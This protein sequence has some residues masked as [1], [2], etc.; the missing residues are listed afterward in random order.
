MHSLL[1]PLLDV[2]VRY[3]RYTVIMNSVLRCIKL[4]VFVYCIVRVQRTSTN[5]HGFA[6]VA[7]EPTSGST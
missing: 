3:E 2:T 7:W 6:T 5:L 4:Y 1:E